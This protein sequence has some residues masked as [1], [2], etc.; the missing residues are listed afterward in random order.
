MV[1]VLVRGPSGGQSR[2]SCN[3]VRTRLSAPSDGPTTTFV[4]EQTGTVPRRGTSRVDCPW[5]AAYALVSESLGQTTRCV[6]DR[7]NRG[8]YQGEGR[9]AWTVPGLRRMPWFPKAWDRPRATFVTAQT[10][11]CT[12]ARDEPRGLS[13]VC[14][15]SHGSRKPG[16]DH[17][18]RSFLTSL[19]SVPAFSTRCV[20]S[21]LRLGQSRL[22]PRAAL[23]PHSTW[24]VPALSTLARP[25]GLPSRR[26]LGAR[27]QKAGPVC[28]NTSVSTR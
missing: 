13:L 28:H 22:S 25:Q 12:K 5:F 2:L 10:G 1:S 14:G 17:A 7:A 8:L 11:D 21:S 20:R 24:V 15:A 3:P 16:T 19:G 27:G 4:T 23:D 18:L 6:R 9:V 26:H